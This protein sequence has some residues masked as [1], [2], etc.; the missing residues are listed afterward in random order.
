MR[1]YNPWQHII[2]AD[3]SQGALQNYDKTKTAGRTSH[4]DCLS[5]KQMW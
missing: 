4:T 3:L 5:P 1:H 2:T